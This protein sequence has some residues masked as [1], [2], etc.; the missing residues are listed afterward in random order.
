[1][2]YVK[3]TTGDEWLIDLN[4]GVAD[5]LDAFVRDAYT[6]DLFDA[7]QMMT[8][9]ARPTN[10]VSVASCIC[11]EQREKRNLTPADFGRRWKG[12]VAYKLQQALWKEYGDFYPNPT[13]AALINSTQERLQ[14]LSVYEGEL[15]KKAMDQLENTMQEA[16]KEMESIIEGE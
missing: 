2:Q 10:V 14:S 15:V 12:E 9:L 3:D 16:V 6:V 4:L 1:M 7:V 11:R 13:I 8:L 5:E